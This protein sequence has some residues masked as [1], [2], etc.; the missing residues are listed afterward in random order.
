KTNGS[1]RNSDGTKVRIHRPARS[2]R[3]LASRRPRRPRTTTTGPLALTVEHLDANLDTTQP[4]E[5]LLTRTEKSRSP[6]TA[7]RSAE[8]TL[9]SRRAS[10]PDSSKRFPIHS[11]QKLLST[12]PCCTFKI[13]SPDGTIGPESGSHQ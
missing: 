10:A 5:T 4:S 7:V 2:N 3:V 11:R 8:R 13:K 9:T 12:I 1:E 6:V